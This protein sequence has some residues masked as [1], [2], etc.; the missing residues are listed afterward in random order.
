MRVLKVDSGST[1]LTPTYIHVT[2]MNYGLSYS[3]FSL[4]T[5]LNK[6]REHHTA[7]V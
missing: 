2:L 6:D 4:E 5:G 1:K 3:G 7:T